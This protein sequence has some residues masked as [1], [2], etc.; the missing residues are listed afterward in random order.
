MIPQASIT[1]AG[2]AGL[3]P[4]APALPA[5]NTGNL[6]QYEVCAPEAE[7]DLYVKPADMSIADFYRHHG[8]KTLV[9]RCIHWKNA[10]SILKTGNLA[11]YGSYKGQLSGMLRR[12]DKAFV[13][14][15]PSR[16]EQS[17]HPEVDDS[18][19]YI[20]DDDD[21]DDDLVISFVHDLSV[22]DNYPFYTGSDFGKPVPDTF[23]TVPSLPCTSPLTVKVTSSEILAM[24]KIPNRSLTAIW[25]PT[26]RRRQF[27]AKLRQ[28]GIDTVD[29][30]PLVDFI[31]PD[32]PLP[33]RLTV[34]DRSP[35]LDKKFIT[36]PATDYQHTLLFKL[37][38]AYWSRATSLA[39]M[40]R[41][42]NTT[43]NTTHSASATGG[44]IL[45]LR[46]NG[47]LSSKINFKS[48]I[49]E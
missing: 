3:L 24:S 37:A 21:E 9:H 43:F 40:A 22:L 13:Y 42:N 28:A 29:G 5:Q 38:G 36:R 11:P 12:A 48:S 8:Y 1:G 26:A 10:V 41:Q 17:P 30:L 33:S 49:S 34:K 15:Y 7:Q 44:A 18:K 23:S 45:P 14:F 31:N 16:N 47:F 4:D 6:K 27:I 2:P 19:W 35:L 20:D 25:V 32:K 39:G 46:A